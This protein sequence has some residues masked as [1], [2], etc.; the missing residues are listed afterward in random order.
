ML[1]YVGPVP[2]RAKGV[3]EVAAR[4]QRLGPDLLLDVAAEAG[5]GRLGGAPHA[6]AAELVV[7]DV[8]ERRGVQLVDVGVQEGGSSLVVPPLSWGA[9]VV[10]GRVVL[11]CAGGLESVVVHAGVA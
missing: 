9:V 2:P 1:A 8:V 5:D 7:E 3:L 11:D 10:V 4:V 6:L